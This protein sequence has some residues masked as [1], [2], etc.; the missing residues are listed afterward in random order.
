VPIAFAAHTNVVID[1]NQT[2][3]STF[4]AAAVPPPA[5]QRLG[6][7]VQSAVFDAVNGIENRYTP[8]HVQ[9]AA[10]AEA[11]PHAAAAGAAYETPLRLFPSPTTAANAAPTAPPR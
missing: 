8:I 9:P 11:D 6:A 5:A 1:W 10:P 7:I 4:Q 2:M 3:L